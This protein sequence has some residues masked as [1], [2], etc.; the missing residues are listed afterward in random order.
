MVEIW[1][2]LESL[3]RCQLDW[4]Y[5]QVM[6]C[7]YES[8]TMSVKVQ[9]QQTKPVPLHR[10][11]R[12]GDVISPK[13]FTNAME[14]MSKTLNWKGRGFYINSEYISHLRFADD[15]VIMAGMMQ[16]LQLM[17]NDL[18]DS[19]V[20]IGLRMNLN[21]T[22]VMFNEHVL[23]EPI[24]IH[25]AALEVVQKYV[26]LGQTLQLGRNIFEDEVNRG[27]QLGWA[28]FGKLRRVFSSS[29]P[30]SLKTK[31]FNQCVLLV[32]TYEAE[33]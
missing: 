20:S 6:R 1:S 3:Q 22:K 16:D 15:I 21:K 25:G 14:D 13:L 29:I 7:L 27:I 31:I 30:Q 17:L 23:R 19:S 18:A 28:T 5:I 8:A 10:G 33:K 11:V 12:Q 24:A 4:R 26:Y 32:V 9:K 2:V